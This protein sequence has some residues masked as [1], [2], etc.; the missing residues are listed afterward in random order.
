MKHYIIEG[1][2]QGVGYRIWCAGQANKLELQ[3]WVRNLE[4][5]NV[6]VVAVG[7]WDVLAVFEKRLWKGSPFASV[8]QVIKSSLPTQ[9]LEQQ[10]QSLHDE[11]IILETAQE[12]LS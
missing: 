4:N 7:R 2:V 5:G 11:F 6:E 10:R 1:R 9:H 8:N 3:G 12:A